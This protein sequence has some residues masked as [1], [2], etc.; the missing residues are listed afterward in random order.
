MANMD[1]SAKPLREDAGRLSELLAPV[2]EFALAHVPPIRHLP[3]PDE[4]STSDSGGRRVGGRTRTSRTIAAASVDEAFA[5]VDRLLAPVH[6][7]AVAAF[8]RMIDQLVA[9]ACPRHED[10]ARLARAIMLRVDRF[11]LGLFQEYKGD[12][13]RVRLSAEPVSATR[14]H[15]SHEA[16]IAAGNFKLYPVREPSESKGQHTRVYKQMFIR[17]DALPTLIVAR[18]RDDALEILRLRNG[19]AAEQREALR[20]PHTP[21]SGESGTHAPS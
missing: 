18:S 12:V 14:L 11:G 10:N 16:V 9:N 19:A 7:I 13:H 20:T 5:A 3:P 1:P 6:D 8:Q 17:R 4:A 21:Q 15:R 2:R